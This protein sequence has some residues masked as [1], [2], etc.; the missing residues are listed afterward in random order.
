MKAAFGM[1]NKK[2]QY[3]IL[4]QYGFPDDKYNIAVNIW[5][6]NFKTKVQR[7]IKHDFI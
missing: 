1:Y 2:I 4:W 6:E 3:D 5:S 7:T